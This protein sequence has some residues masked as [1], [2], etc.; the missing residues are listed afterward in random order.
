MKATWTCPSC[1]VE[2]G[3]ADLEHA[4]AARCPDCGCQLQIE[5]DATVVL[6]EDPDSRPYIWEFDS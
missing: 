4:R 6:P 1:H 3:P 5:L 2:L